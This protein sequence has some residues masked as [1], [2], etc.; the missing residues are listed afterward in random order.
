M[1]PHDLIKGKCPNGHRWEWM[2]WGQYTPQ[3]LLQSLEAG[4]V[5]LHCYICGSDFALTEEAII[6]KL[7]KQLEN[8]DRSVN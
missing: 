6:L 5:I 7:R 3:S 2:P 8:T 1:T 4:T